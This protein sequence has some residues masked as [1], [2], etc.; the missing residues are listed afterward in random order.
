MH[1]CHWEALFLNLSDSFISLDSEL[2][3]TNTQSDKI[4][5]SMEF[6]GC[7]CREKKWIA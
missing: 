6:K 1:I 5:E 4:V 3:A 7:G 2:P